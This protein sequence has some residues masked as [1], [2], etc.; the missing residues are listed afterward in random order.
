MIG[1]PY[2]MAPEV[3]DTRA[4]SGGYN[5]RADIWSLGITAIEI[6]QGRPPLSELHPMKAI[7]MIAKNDPPQLD[8]DGDFEWSKEFKDFVAQCLKKD[9][10]TRASAEDLLK[11]P[12][13]TG[14]KPKKLVADL[15]KR[16]MPDI[17][18]ARAAKAGAYDDS[19][20][21]DSEDDD[22]GTT[23]FRDTRTYKCNT[24]I[25]TGNNS[26]SGMATVSFNKKNGSGKNM[27]IPDFMKHIKENGALT[28]GKD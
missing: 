15:V 20:S 13:I 25:E 9:C 16:C 21:S 8:D 5:S 22:N 19:S 11:H 23:S 28:E 3:V 2:W 4:R 27:E 24:T 1:T 14:A 18:K 12:F 7:F 26:T 17:E 6:S 10:K